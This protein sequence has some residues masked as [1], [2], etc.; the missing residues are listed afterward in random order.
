MPD[1]NE[2]PVCYQLA[3]SA[4]SRQRV[5]SPVL[6]TTEDEVQAANGLH[7]G[8]SSDDDSDLGDL[9]DDFSDDSQLGSDAGGS[10]GEL[11]SSDEDDAPARRGGKARA[12]DSDEGSEEDDDE[13]DDPLGGAEFSGSD[14]ESD[15]E[16][17][18]ALLP[19][20]QKSAWLDR[21]R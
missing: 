10:G 5:D 12:A 8:G 6:A 17:E 21:Q 18:E 14:M 16:A 4:A 2:S 20:E 3:L 1:T 19:S 15:G 7:D 11:W 13:D 9:R